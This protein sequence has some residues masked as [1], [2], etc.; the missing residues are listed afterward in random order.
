MSRNDKPP[1]LDS[2]SAA[3]C[4]IILDDDGQ[5]IV[6][7]AGNLRF[8]ALP[9]AAVLDELVAALIL[10]EP[11]ESVVT[12]VGLPVLERRHRPHLIQARAFKELVGVERG[13]PLGQVEDRKIQRA[14]GGGIERR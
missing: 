12:R 3:I 13:V 10:D 14:I 1:S 2:P 7:V 9:G 4:L 8:K 6:N 5:T 11:S